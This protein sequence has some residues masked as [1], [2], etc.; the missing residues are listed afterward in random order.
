MDP[1]GR[2]GRV[3]RIR[4]RPPSHQRFRFIYPAPASGNKTRR[5]R[6]DDVLPTEHEPG[7]MGTPRYKI[8]RWATNDSAAVGAANLAHFQS[9]I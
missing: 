7:G 4:D 9:D 1:F 3:T 6:R 2:L 8:Q 5:P